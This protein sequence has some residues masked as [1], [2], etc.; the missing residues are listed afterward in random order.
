[1]VVTEA[2]STVDDDAVRLSIGE[3]SAMTHLS[4]KTLRR[5]HEQGFLKPAQVDEWSGY[6][7]YEPRQ[8]PMA[9]TVRRLRELDMPVREIADLLAEADTARREELLARH[10]HRLEERL[11]QTRSSV[12][13]LRQLL[14]TRTDA[15]TVERRAVPARTVAAVGERVALGDVLTWYATAMADLDAALDEH[16]LTA[17]G[18][19]GALYDNALFTEEEGELTVYLD[20][21]DPPTSGRVR[22]LL[23]PAVEL[24]VAVHPGPHTDI[25]ITY[26]RL[27]QWVLDRELSIAGPVHETY[28]VGPRDTPDSTRWRTEIGWPIRGR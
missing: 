15:L 6:R 18:P 21:A 19:A 11:E 5:Y 28:V 22:P 1:V 23:I 24:A 12:A 8:I 2:V 3:F 27:G 14:V 7:Y 26:G 17:V 13:A 25:D 4:V 16:G 10:L 20:V 9:Q